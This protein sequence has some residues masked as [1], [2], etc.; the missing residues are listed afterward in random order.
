VGWSG[1]VWGF[2]FEKNWSIDQWEL[3]GYT[4]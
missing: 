3:S 1:G 4:Q 2:F